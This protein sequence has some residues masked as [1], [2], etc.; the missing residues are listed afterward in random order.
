[1][2]QQSNPEPE[3]TKI[4]TNE[5]NLVSLFLQIC[6][7]IERI[8][9]YLLR[10]LGQLGLH[11]TRNIIRNFRLIA[12]LVLVFMAFGTTLY[13]KQ[14]PNF[15]GEAFVQC[16]GFDNATLD[17][18]V[19]KLNS[20]LGNKN[21]TYLASLLNIPEAY[22]KQI[23][24]IHMGY[25]IDLDND[26]ITDEICYEKQGLLN[27]IEE[28]KLKGAD[29]EFFF[30]NKAI[31]VKIPNIAYILIKTKTLNVNQFNII[32]N[33]VLQYIGNAPHLIKVNRNH[34]LR[35]HDK[36]KVLN[37][38]LSLLDSIQKIEYIEGARK[39]NE[40]A[41]SSDKIIF[42]S[43]QEK[44]KQLFHEEI[45]KISEEKLS[46]ETAFRNN[47]DV[48]TVISNF[49]PI[50]NKISLIKILMIFSI[51]GFILGYLIGLIKVSY[52]YIKKFIQENK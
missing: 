40:N 27:I 17:I 33:G 2:D 15:E 9:R 16:N 31:K 1:M 24:S 7:G 47:A 48:I 12:I 5:I 30:E 20:I 10:M 32:S 37:S 38:Q 42:T 3:N 51:L 29:G 50:I 46:L 36:I 52:P 11:F 45:F 4:N 41:V 19:K 44:D 49:K 21:Y 14:E 6:K 26:G 34:R 35:L 22:A 18:E 25:G 43:Y 39:K 23:S 13:L 28:R 8:F